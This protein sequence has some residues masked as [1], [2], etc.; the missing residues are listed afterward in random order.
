MFKCSNF[1]FYQKV[2]YLINKQQKSGTK[3][4][5]LKHKAEFLSQEAVEF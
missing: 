5:K 4:T 3:V 1:L 2:T